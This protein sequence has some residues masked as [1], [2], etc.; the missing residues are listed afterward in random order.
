MVHFM[1]EQVQDTAE[2]TNDL[3]KRIFDAA[4]VGKQ[5]SI[6]DKAEGL[7]KDFQ[8][9]VGKKTRQQVKIERKTDALL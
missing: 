5:I 3:E 6:M 4:A 9:K 2:T 7:S 1:E 8:T